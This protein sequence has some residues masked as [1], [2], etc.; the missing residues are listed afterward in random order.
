M[1]EP[2]ALLVL[3]MTSENILK[4]QIFYKRLKAKHP[5]LLIPFISMKFTSWKECVIMITFPSVSLHFYTPYDLQLTQLYKGIY[6]DIWK[7]RQAT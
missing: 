3:S 6:P 1:V 4:T 7:S 5:S 2:L